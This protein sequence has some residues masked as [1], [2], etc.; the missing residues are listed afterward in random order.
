MQPSS[1]AGPHLEAKALQENP[2][3]PGAQVIRRPGGKTRRT[4]GVIDVATFEY[5]PPTE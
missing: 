4:A 1:L 3:P 2:T 5:E